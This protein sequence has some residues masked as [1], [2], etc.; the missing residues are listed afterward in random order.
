MSKQLE[1]KIALITGGSRGIGA[2]IAKRLA[3][4]GATVAITYTKGADAAAS[5]VNEIERG[6]RK[7][8]AIQA[9]ATD[10]S[11]VEAAVNKTVATFGGLDI[12]VNN[13]GTAIPKS[14]EET[15]LE[16]LDRLIDVNLRGAFVATQAALK[17]MKS[18]GRII[19]IGSSVGER[20][21]VPGLVPYSATK[22]AVKM[23]SQ[24]LSREVGSRGITVN[25]IQPG[26]IDT[27]LNPAAGEW[28]VPQKAVT[29]LDRYGHVEEVAA[30]VAF[31]AGPES[32]YITGANLTVDGGTN[33]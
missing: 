29:A 26:P 13:A 12:L 10:A 3:A 18:G 6:G 1:G 22:G 17:Q 21:M 9:D 11:A 14:F 5:V 27:E 24:G 32:S 25:N 19:M 30:L 20:V 4:D 28:A 16:E 15:T 33:A 2:A 8:I 7:A 23:F 31:V